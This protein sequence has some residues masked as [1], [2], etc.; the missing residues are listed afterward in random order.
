[1]F[2]CSR[3]AAAMLV[4]IPGCHPRGAG[5]DPG[6]PDP[7]RVEAPPSEIPA[8]ELPWVLRFVALPDSDFA[9]EALGEDPW[10]LWATIELDMHVDDPY[11]VGSIRVEDRVDV[12][13]EQLAQWGPQLEAPPSTVWLLGPEGACAA[14]LAKHTARLELHEAGMTEVTV[15]FELTGCEGSIWA[16]FAIVSGTPPPELSWSPAQTLTADDPGLVAVREAYVAKA[17]DMGVRNPRVEVRSVPATT[18]RVLEVLYGAASECTGFLHNALG[19]FSDDGFDPWSCGL[20]GTNCFGYELLGT[21]G[22]PQQA[23]LA[24]FINH[25][26]SL[27]IRSLADED[28]YRPA[29]GDGFVTIPSIDG[30]T[31]DERKR[32][33]PGLYP[34]DPDDDDTP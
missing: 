8:P 20:L 29:P 33:F 27:V 13:S 12:P 17:R 34:C 26:Y 15:S 21:V 25:H 1:M 24:V 3:L 32:S 4:C 30:P 11:R 6:P 7:R 19:V 5:P 9:L 14:V 2:A 23:H 31:E 18:P 28:R 22:T 16:P 10:L